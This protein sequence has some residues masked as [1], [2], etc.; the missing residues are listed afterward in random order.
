MKE[1]KNSFIREKTFLIKTDYKEF[2]RPSD[3]FNLEAIAI[4]DIKF[5]GSSLD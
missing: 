4:S 1:L 2:I 5:F 3:S